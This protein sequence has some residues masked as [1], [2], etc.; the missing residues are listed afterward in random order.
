MADR[1]LVVGEALVDVVHRHDGS[2]DEHAGGS[3]ANVAIGLARLGHPVEFAARFGTD[4]HGEMVR[5]H[6]TENPLVTLSTGTQSGDHTSTAQAYLDETGAAT[7]VFDIDWDVESVLT[8][9]PTAHFHTGSIAGTLQP[10]A[11]A[12]TD[13]ARRARETGTVSYDP[14]ARPDVM[15]EPHE[16]RAQIESLV[17][18]ADVVKA[19]D[20]D[21]EWLYEGAPVGEVMKLWGTLG[22]SLVVI[23]RGGDG[24]SAL[25]PGTGEYVERD[26]YRVDVVDTVGAGD[27]FMS[28]LLSGL[29][30]DGLLGSAQAREALRGAPMAAFEPALRRAVGCGAITVSR[31]G[32]N[33]PTR[34]ELPF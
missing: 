20:E 12:V 16:V 11:S 14:N 13:A 33:P 8:D 6:L 5:E 26:G 19:S 17:G 29:L 10:G 4:R 24:F 21:V 28:G 27:S 2:V 34:E 9:A 3:P 1:I 31:A 7:Y 23:T 25:V 15:G 30:D 18:L 22:P 32:A